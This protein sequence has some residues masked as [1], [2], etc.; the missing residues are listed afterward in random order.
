MS[1]HDQIP[2]YILGQKASLIVAG[3]SFFLACVYAFH[4]WLNVDL[5]FYSV[6]IRRE[7]LAIR[8]FNW[9][10]FAVVFVLFSKANTL[11]DILLWRAMARLSLSFLILSELAYQTIVLIPEIK[12]RRANGRE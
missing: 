9:I 2:L 12:K 3:L 8:A 1:V 10:I 5:E 4:L 7:R 11:E 6:A